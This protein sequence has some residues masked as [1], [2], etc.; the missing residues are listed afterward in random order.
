KDLFSCG[1]GGRYASEDRPLWGADGLTSIRPRQPRGLC[2]V[3]ISGKRGEAACVRDSSDTPTAMPR[4]DDRARAGLR[5]DAWNDAVL[6]L[7]FLKTSIQ[8]DPARKSLLQLAFNA[9][10]GRP[11]WVDTVLRTI[12]GV[13]VPILA[14]LW[15]QT[16]AIIAAQHLSRKRK[17]HLL[18]QHIFQLNP[19]A[20]INADL[21]LSSRDRSFSRMRIRRRR[22]IEQVEICIHIVSH[23]LDAASAGN[24]HR[25]GQLATQ[26]DI[27]NATRSFDLFHQIGLSPGVQGAALD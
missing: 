23:R 4:S 3:R 15:A 1:R 16:L 14:A 11:T 27:G 10:Q 7:P 2:S 13:L 17:Q 24:F 26:A 25:R 22:A 5:C 20:L 21:A 9:F 12:A 19:V 18:F 8:P 6:D